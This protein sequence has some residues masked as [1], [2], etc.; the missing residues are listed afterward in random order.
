MEPS[1][2]ELDAVDVGRLN[3]P[4]ADAFRYIAAALGARFAGDGAPFP[5]P[6][7][8][9]RGDG[10]DEAEAGHVGTD[11]VADFPGS[12]DA[13]AAADPERA[14]LLDRIPVALI[15]ADGDSVAFMNR[16]ALATLGYRSCAVLDAA[17]GIGALFPH[18]DRPIEG[19]M[20]VRTAAG[21]TF[22]AKVEMSPIE[23]GFSTALLLSVLPAAQPR[24][25]R[26]VPHR[27]SVPGDPLMQFLNAN[28]DPVAIITEQGQVE[29]CNRAFAA[30]GPSDRAVVRLD[31]RLGPSD[32]RHLLNTVA[33]SFSVVDGTAETGWP[34]T[35]DGHSYRVSAGALEGGPLACVVFHRVDGGAVEP[36]GEI[37]VA[38]AEAAIGEVGR[39][40]SEAS[41]LLVHDR[42]ASA[43][44]PSEV[45][46]AAVNFLRSILLAVSAR[47]P[48]GSVIT[49]TST[50]ESVAIRLAPHDCD[51]LAAI[52][53][54]DR[55]GHL[56]RNSG[57][58]VAEV[59]GRLVVGRSAG[60]ASIPVCP[61]QGQR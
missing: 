34:L 8:A 18:N 4:E 27:A 30:L 54:S 24:P 39:L 49:V 3:K 25:G 36:G 20:A 40:V 58:A 11:V 50:G 37:L 43:A 38:N 29:A 44:A 28:P 46:P 51:A 45:D 12:S 41:V 52:A 21:S 32:V 23:W 56:A 61:V 42:Q 5:A 47:A 7:E 33:L 53:G 31:D 35:A 16:T 55:I 15:I 10:S 59:D 22:A 26:R 48:V 57:L 17:G 19:T 6:D 9:E 13:M 2:D 60:S 1:R 14:R